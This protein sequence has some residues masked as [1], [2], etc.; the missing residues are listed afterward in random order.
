MISSA[1][2]C[3][4][5]AGT[6]ISVDVFKKNNIN[7]SRFGILFVG[8]GAFI[9]AVFLGDILKTLQLA[10][11][12]FTSGLT[13]P[14]I[15]GFY[16]DKTHVSSKGAFWSLIIGGSISLLLLYFS[17]FNDYAVLIGI[18]FSL[19]PLLIFREVKK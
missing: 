7:I 19:I 2:S 3:L 11:T 1:D 14:I 10:Y 6:I 13:L 12:V 8:L 4:L 18:I 9:L 16:R 15:F 17:S 5:S